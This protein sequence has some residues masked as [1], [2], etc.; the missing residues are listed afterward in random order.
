MVYH[1]IQEDGEIYMFN[2]EDVCHNIDCYVKIK[3]KEYMVYD[4]YH[5]Q[6]YQLEHQSIDDYCCFHLHLEPYQS[7]VIVNGNS[8]KKRLKKGNLIYKI[9]DVNISMKAYNE[10]K[11]LPIDIHTID[12]YLGQL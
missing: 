4:A 3:G 10:K 6:T 5:N 9:N 7:L 1:Y 8:Q 11:Y 12:T 2:N